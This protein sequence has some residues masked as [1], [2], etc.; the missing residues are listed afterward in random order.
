MIDA[1]GTVEEVVEGSP[2]DHPAAAQRRYL[3]G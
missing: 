1:K 3:A 2:L